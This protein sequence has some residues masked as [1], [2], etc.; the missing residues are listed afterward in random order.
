MRVADVPAVRPLP[1]HPVPPPVKPPKSR[2]LARID[3]DIPDDMGALPSPRL[4]PSIAPLAVDPFRLKLEFIWQ[5]PH[6]QWMNQL[7][8][9][10]EAARKAGDTE[11][12]NALTAR[13]TA[14]AEKYLRRSD[15]PN[16]DGLR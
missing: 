11:T 14:W 1:A 16:L 5:K 12:Y 15:P 6:G 8:K 9:D 3:L 10:I 2:T 7:L 4:L 13:Y